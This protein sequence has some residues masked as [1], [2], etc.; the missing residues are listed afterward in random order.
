MEAPVPPVPMPGARSHERLRNFPPPEDWDHHVEHDAKAHP[1]K[2]PRT[3]SLI[4]TICFNCES[5]C[6]LLAYVDHEDLSIKK[7]EG[8]PAHPGSRGRNCAKGPATINQVKDPERILHP[9]RRVGERGS[10]DPARGPV[11]N[12]QV[13]QIPHALEQPRR[14]DPERGLDARNHARVDAERD[15]AAAPRREDPLLG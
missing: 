9:L 13:V 8:N 4:P 1:R 7:F 11:A 3:Y 14:L 15:A 2:V 12:R 5:S 10:V 6:G